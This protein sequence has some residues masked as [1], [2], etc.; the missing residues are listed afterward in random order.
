MIWTTDPHWNSYSIS[1]RKVIGES[2][3]FYFKSCKFTDSLHFVMGFLIQEVGIV[4]LE[5]VMKPGREQKGRNFGRRR[6]TPTNYVGQ[7]KNGG[8]L[9]DKWGTTSTTATRIFP[10]QNILWTADLWNQC[11]M[12]TGNSLQWLVLHSPISQDTTQLGYPAPL[13][14]MAGLGCSGGW[15]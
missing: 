12:S 4:A 7:V 2:T 10:T 1:W 8:G 15:V 14:K 5:I 13:L 9:E 6:W 3:R 11:L